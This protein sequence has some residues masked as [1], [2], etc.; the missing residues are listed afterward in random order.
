M[1]VTAVTPSF[2]PDAIFLTNSA[3]N[4]RCDAHI[5]AQNWKWVSHY[6]SVWLLADA[7]AP[8]SRDLSNQLLQSCIVFEVLFPR[9]KKF[10][11]NLVPSLVLLHNTMC[12]MPHIYAAYRY[13]K[14]GNMNMWFSNFLFLLFPAERIIYVD[15]IHLWPWAIQV[16]IDLNLTVVSFYLSAFLIKAD[17][18][19]KN[20]LNN[21]SLWL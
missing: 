6:R 4:Q 19:L 14:D 9:G 12:W 3:I 18:L 15:F 10:S 1:S 21:W 8:L 20:K 7:Q 2:L 13:C 16:F 5:S 11:R 17:V